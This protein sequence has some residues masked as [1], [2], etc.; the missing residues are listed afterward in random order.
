LDRF[1]ELYQ[2]RLRTYTDIDLAQA[3]RKLP[4][5]QFGFC[6]IYNVFNYLPLEHIK[7][8]LTA[9]AA[10]T[11]PGGTICFT[12]NDCDRVGGVEYFE[13]R[14]MC[15]TPQKL[16]LALCENLGY[17]I[18][19]CYEMDNSISWIEAEL[20]GNLVSL[21]GGQTLAEIVYK[22]NEIK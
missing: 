17:K 21:R 18:T 5:S 14:Y 10:V 2:S 1:N 13:Q 15:Y 19:H 16:I 6:L 9:I 3:V 20:P 11:R 7:D 12:I 22:G 4:A 8:I